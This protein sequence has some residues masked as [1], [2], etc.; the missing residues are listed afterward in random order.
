MF[1]SIIIPVYDVEKYLAECIDS[2]L[3]QTFEDYEIILVDDGSTDD[4]GRICD[5]Y[6][7]TNSKIN[8]IHQEN[9]GLSQA[10]NTGAVAA[11]GRYIIFLDSDD[12]I[13][14]YNFLRKLYECILKTNPDLVQ[15]KYQKY[16]DTNKT[17][18]SCLYQFP[19]MD[20]TG[21]FAPLVS[22]LVEE[23]SYLGMAWNKCIRK[24]I[25]SE[26]NVRFE[27]KLLSEDID[28]N[29]QLMIQMPKMILINEP[30]VAYRQ[31][32]NS[33][34]SAV[35]LKS[36]TDNIYISNKWQRI[37]EDAEIDEVLRKALLGALSKYYSN[38]LITYVRVTDAKKAEYKND[39]KKLSVLLRFAMSKRPQIVSVVYR[40]F[41]FDGTIFLLSIADRRNKRG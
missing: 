37:I 40:I 17:L 16:D 13:L 11:A 12:F 4:S 41:G 25:L 5:M 38:L 7:E 35:K 29:F 1:F 26:H 18:D 20:T 8:V 2:I 24:S 22:K 36:L 9:Q 32:P 19:D 28:W 33:I 23:D 34:T 39:L 10:R 14:N 21:D 6:A 27:P 30:F 31:R 3:G 15:Y